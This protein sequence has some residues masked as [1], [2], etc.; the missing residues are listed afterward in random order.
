[1]SLNTWQIVNIWLK[2]IQL[3]FQPSHKCDGNRN[4][5]YKTLPLA[6]AYRIIEGCRGFSRN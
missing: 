4:V 1:L 2:P 6:S 3:V 5:R